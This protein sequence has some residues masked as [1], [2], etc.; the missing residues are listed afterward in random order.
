MLTTS[1]D[2]MLTLCLEYLHITSRD[3]LLRN[4]KKPI[5]GQPSDHTIDLGKEQQCA[6]KEKQKLSGWVKDFS[7]ERTFK[8]R[9][10]E[11]GGIGLLAICL[12]YKQTGNSCLAVRRKDL[13]WTSAKRKTIWVENKNKN[14]VTWVL[15]IKKQWEP[16]SSKRGWGLHSEHQFLKVLIEVIEHN[17]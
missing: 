9:S 2:S 14:G 13:E 3:T 4:S 7:T 10:W 1:P 8:H 15:I 17:W 5:Q 16:V 11:L 12:W 6:K